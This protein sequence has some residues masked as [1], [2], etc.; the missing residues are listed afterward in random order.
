V[1][2]LGF[3]ADR[4]YQVVVARAMRWRQ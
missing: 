1:A 3:V 4:A 2:M